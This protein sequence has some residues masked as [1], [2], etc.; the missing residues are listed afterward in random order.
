LEPAATGSAPVTNSGQ[1][2]IG[3]T[4]LKIK[5]LGFGRWRLPF[6]AGNG[7]PGNTNANSTNRR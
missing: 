3:G 2:E 5:L 1:R 4:G 6:L 7:N